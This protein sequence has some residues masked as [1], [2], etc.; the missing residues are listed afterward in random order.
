V[1]AA[2]AIGKPELASATTAGLFTSD[3]IRRVFK[4]VRGIFNSHG[5]VAEF[6]EVQKQAALEK[7][8][9]EGVKK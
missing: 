1:R 5:M 8:A 2:F 7:I 3:E 4:L 6:R 9:A